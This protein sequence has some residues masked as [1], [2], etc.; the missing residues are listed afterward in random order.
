MPNAVKTA[1]LQGVHVETASPQFILF[2]HPG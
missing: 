1:D 2:V